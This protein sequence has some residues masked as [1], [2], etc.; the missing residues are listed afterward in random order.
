VC[1]GGEDKRSQ[2]DP[3]QK[4]G[5]H[6]I[7]ATPGRISDLLHT[8]KVHFDL[9]KYICLDEGD[10]MLD[11]GFDEEVQKIMNHFKQ[12]RQTLL[13]SATM[14]Q[15]FQDFAKDVL[16]KPVLV[17]VGR[18]GAANLDVIQEVCCCCC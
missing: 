7:V 13:F 14:P 16:V 1:P 3:I 9:C 5:V 6:C 2:I 11:M 15:K 17:N 12:Q 8:H 10:R 4:M 18:A